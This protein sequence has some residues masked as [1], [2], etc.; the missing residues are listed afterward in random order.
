MINAHLAEELLVCPLEVFHIIDPGN[1]LLGSQSLGEDGGG[2]IRVF[3]VCHCNKEVSML[4]DCFL[5]D[6]YRC[7]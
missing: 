2:D 5:Q 3:I 4:L 7:C 1:Y 6:V